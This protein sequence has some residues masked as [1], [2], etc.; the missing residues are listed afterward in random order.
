MGEMNKT[1][2]HFWKM[3]VDS[4]GWELGCLIGTGQTVRL[5]RL[6]VVC[7]TKP[8]QGVSSPANARWSYAAN[9]PE[10]SNAGG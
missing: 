9:F 3:L 5:V 6:F 2:P 7:F 1:F 4:R 10:G 8:T